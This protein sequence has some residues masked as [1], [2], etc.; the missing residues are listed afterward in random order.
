MLREDDV[1]GAIAAYQ[2][3]MTLDPAAADI[4]ADL[5]DLYMDEGRDDEAIATAEQALKISSTITRRIACSAWC[6]RSS[7]E[8]WRRTAARRAASPQDNLNNA[9]LHLEQAIETPPT[10]ADFTPRAVLARLYVARRNYD[11]AIAVLPELV[12]QGLAGRRVAAGRGVR[13]R[14]PRRRSG[15]VARGSRAGQPAAVRERSATSTRASGAGPIPRTRTS[16]R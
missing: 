14:R 1:D 16:W 15:Q 5:A 10:F 6:T 13:R 3:A 12:K 4:P 9:I 7:V 8:R 2:R 11:K